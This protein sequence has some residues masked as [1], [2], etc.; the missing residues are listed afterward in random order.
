MSELVNLFSP[1]K[2]ANFELK[3]RIIMA[4]LTRCRADIGGLASALQVEYY[5]QRASAGL[6]ITEATPINRYGI[7][8]QG[9]PCI[10]TT[11]QVEAWKKVT[12]S[13]HNAGSLIFCQLW[14]VGRISHPLFLDGDLPL[15]P[16]AISPGGQI[17]TSEG[18]KDRIVPAEM[19]LEQIKSTIQDY[20]Q[21]AQNAIDAGFDGVEIHGANGYLIDQFISENANTR[22]DNYGGSFENR[23]RFLHEVLDAVIAQIGS[24][25][26]ALRLSPSGIVNGIYNQEPLPIFEYIIQSLN[27]YNLVYLHLMQPYPAI[28]EGLHLQYL[29]NPAKHFKQ[30]YDGKIISNSGFTL[31]SA[32]Q[33]IQEKWIDA[34]AFGKAFISNPDLPYR[35]QNNIELNPWDVK[36]FYTHGAEG[37][38]DYPFAKS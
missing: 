30:F 18:I 24:D 16:S 17:R 2:L 25:K 9:V 4:P 11:E 22:S 8:W 20:A 26:V 19:S 33:A 31:E 13:V 36:T 5:T 14:H 1:V 3:N 38:I 37:Y 15:A 21:A 23:A 34:I 35:L 32:N 29:R 27:K 7:G 6:I 10:Y 28:E 12:D